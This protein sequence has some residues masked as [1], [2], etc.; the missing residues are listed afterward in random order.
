MCEIN[1]PGGRNAPCQESPLA[2]GSGDYRYGNTAAHRCL[3][4]ISW[5]PCPYK[6]HYNIVQAYIKNSPPFAPLFKWK[7]TPQEAGGTLKG[8]SALPSCFLFYFFLKWQLFIIIVI[9][10]FNSK[11]TPLRCYDY[12]KTTPLH[13]NWKQH[14]HH[15]LLVFFFS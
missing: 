2:T 1:T 3:R 6:E 11:T 15:F 5:V 14:T 9:I 13:Q 10:I 7:T 12:H 8:A 4:G